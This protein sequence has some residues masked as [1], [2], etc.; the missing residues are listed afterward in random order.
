MKGQLSQGL[1]MPIDKIVDADGLRLADIIT[2]VS[3]MYSCFATKTV[4][5]TLEGLDLTSIL[6]ITKYE[7]DLPACLQGKAR[8]T[9]PGYIPKTDED[10]I[11][12]NLHF[13]TD[14]HNREVYVSQK[15]DGSSFSGAYHNKEFHVSSRNLDIIKDP[16]NSFWK[17]A[18]KYYLEI[19]LAKHFADTG[20]ELVVQ[21]ELCGPGLQANRVGLKE[22]DLFIFNVIDIAGNKDFTFDEMSAFCH[23]NKLQMVPV[24]YRGPFKWKTVEDLLAEAKGTYQIS[25]HEQEGIVIRPTIPEKDMRSRQRVSFKVINNDF[26]LKI[27]E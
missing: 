4:G 18:I 24:L 13:L 1:L 19:I 27:K 9:R 17:V 11:Q 22:F 6:G 2:N 3:A 26:L 14:L 20:Q 12:S 15:M 8:G 16:N 7:P 5:P 25:G 10:R 21:G 23:I